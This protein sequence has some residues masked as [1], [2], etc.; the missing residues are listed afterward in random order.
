M[1]LCPIKEVKQGMLLGKSIYQP[2][3]KLLLGAGYRISSEIRSKLVE[4][5]YNHIYIMEEG[6]EDVVPEDIISDEIRMQAKSTLEGKMSEIKKQSVFQN[7]S[8]QKAIKLI[9]KGYLKNINI[10]YDM[11]KIVEEILK[12]ISSAGAQLLNTVLIK[13]AD[14]Y[15]LD[16]AI[17]VTV[18]SIL[19]GRKYRFEHREL[20][21]LALGS[22]LH[23]IGK[24]I[25]E[26]LKGA[27]KSEKARELY[28]EHPTFG[29][30]LLHNSQSQ[31]I[32]PIEIQIVNQHHEH[33]DGSGFPI[34][35]SGENLPPLKTVVRKTKRHIYRLAEICCISN[36][37][38]NL[39][40]N[41]LK[42][43]QLAPDQAIKKI[44]LDAGTLYNKDVVQM[45][46]NV[47]PHY[48]VGTSIKV[49]DIVDPQL[50][51]YR[52]V[53]AKINDDNIN[54]PVIILTKNKFLKKVKP[55]V[56]DTSKFTHV[57]L[58]LMV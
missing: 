10:T 38:D 1:R 54:K 6:T 23:D 11:R 29:Y 34:G 27:N 50:I 9:E 31:D 32:T 15:F 30:L 20:M 12:D 37:F 2:N 14:S 36:V 58:K 35:L 33:Q 39:V 25:I 52:G 49:M 46:L 13:S 44:I 55:I 7:I 57:E 40:F 4:R 47:V 19:I 16:H 3:G 45:L 17:N 24:S 43:E 22:F 56:I 26:Q 21:S 8:H 41:P 5:K 53:V 51:G 42:K 18:L 48:P 28:R